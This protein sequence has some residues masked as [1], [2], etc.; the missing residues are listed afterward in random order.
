MHEIL[1]VK[2]SFNDYLLLSMMAACLYTDLKYR[3]IYNKVLLPFL[4]AALAATFQAGGWQGFLESVIGFLIGL[5]LLIIPFT[6]GG[7]GGGDV[8]LLAVI[9]ALKGP[10]FVISTCLAGAMAGGALALALLLKHRR[11]L[12]TLSAGLAAASGMLI[13]YRVNIPSPRCQGQNAEPLHLPYSLAIGA[14]V[15]ASYLAGLQ[16]LVR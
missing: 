3:R 8:K 12:S 2:F 9:G 15:A 14:G 10:A 7:V 1:N 4:L 5:A 6:K 16:I 13:R 11:L